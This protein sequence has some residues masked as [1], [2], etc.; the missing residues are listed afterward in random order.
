MTASSLKASSTCLPPPSLFTGSLSQVSV[1]AVDRGSL[2]YNKGKVFVHGASGAT[3][4][5]YARQFR[6]DMARFLRCRA[7][8]LKRGGAMF[9]VCLGRPSSATAPTDQGSLGLLLGDLFQSSWD[10]LVREGVM[11]GEKMD[12]FNVPVYAPTLEEL[13]EAV[14]ADG[15]MGPPP[16]VDRPGDP[17][18]VGRTMAKNVRSILG[19]LVDAHL[20]AALGGELFDRL[21]RRAEWRA[22]EMME[23]M[24]FP[25]VVCSL[26]LA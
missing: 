15:A 8:E 11:D 21:R 22:A 3:G 5:A 17:A 6:A 4:A 14:A 25:H 12:S 1:E 24:R 26:S 20:G 19:V 2:A 9:L 7:A 10:D 23:E 13:R 16:A 18:A